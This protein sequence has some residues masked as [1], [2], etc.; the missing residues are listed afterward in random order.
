MYRDRADR[1]VDAQVL[2]QIDT[3]G[4]HESRDDS[5]QERAFRIDPVART[6]DRDESGQEAVNRQREIPFAALVI[7]NEQP[8]QARRAS[9]NRRVERDTA[10]ALR[11]ESREGAARIK[12]VPSEPEYESAGCADDQVVRFHRYTAV[13]FEYSSEPW[14]ERACAGQRNRS[15]HC[16]Y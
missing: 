8:G 15:A 10:D 6:G 13:A 9:C 2:E 11:V 16:V 5:E 1:I 7:R 14:T 4:H 3:P 12:S